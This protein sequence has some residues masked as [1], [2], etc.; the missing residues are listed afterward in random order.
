[1]ESRGRDKNEEEDLEGNGSLRIVSQTNFARTRETGRRAREKENSEMERDKYR[2]TRAEPIFGRQNASR[3]IVPWCIA[4]YGVNQA[5]CDD[6]FQWYQPTLAL[7]QPERHIYYPSTLRLEQMPRC[8]GPIRASARLSHWISYYSI[9]LVF[10]SSSDT[11]FSISIRWVLSL[12]ATTRFQ[13]TQFLLLLGSY[14]P[15]VASFYVYQIRWLL[16]TIVVKGICCE[17]EFFKQSAECSIFCC[18]QIFPANISKKYV[19]HLI[20]NDWI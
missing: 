8:C 3:T 11:S 17:N 18:R 20:M 16:G 14:V 9:L 6:W 2:V 19:V 4:A 12:P 13:W 1:M 7:Y 15:F 5:S 10:A